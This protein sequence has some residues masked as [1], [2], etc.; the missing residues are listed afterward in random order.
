MRSPRTSAWDLVR[1]RGWACG[2]W[3]SMLC[4]RGLR[5]NGATAATDNGSVAVDG[6]DRL[7][8]RV[9]GAEIGAVAGEDVDPLAAG[10]DEVLGDEVGGVVAAAA[11]HRDVR[12]GGA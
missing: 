2:C 4:H 12:G 7:P 1:A 6:V 3:R 8:S 10:V 5:G 9:C 11:G